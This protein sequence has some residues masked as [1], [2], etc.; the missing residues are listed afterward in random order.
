M[1][2]SPAGFTPGRTPNGGPPQVMRRPKQ[3]DPMVRPKD[4]TKRKPQRP[5][6]ANGIN[7]THTN[8]QN[9]PGQGKT[10]V[11]PQHSGR[12]PLA[13]SSRASPAVTSGPE[14]GRSGFTSPAVAPYTDYPLVTTKRALIEGMRHHV[15]K[16]AS[17]KKIDPRD[18]NE[19]TRPVR[20]HRRDTRAPPA[21]A[22]GAKDE[23]GVGGS[24]LEDDKERE[25]QDILR[26]EKDAQREAEAALVAPSTKSGG[27]KRN[28]F[29]KK[30]KQVFTNNQTDEQKARSK[31]RY[32]EALPWH[33]EDFEN[34]ST[35]VGSYEAALSDT[36]AMLVHGQ[37]GKFRMVPVEKWYKFTPKNHFKPMTIEEAETQMGKKVKEP[38]WYVESQK[39]KFD[40]Q[41]EQMNRRATKKL[42]VAKY[43]GGANGG[44][45]APSTKNEHADTDDLDFDEDRFADDEEA[46]VIEGD[47]HETK[48]AEDRIKRDQLQANIFDLKEEKEYDK[49]EVLEQKEREAEKK[50]GK[51]V[52]KALIKQEKNYVYDSDSS[53]NPYSEKVRCQI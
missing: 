49:A 51:K 33:L 15:A 26:A 47:D 48:Q 31:L 24:G 12:P 23:S 5:P 14:N 19:F 28:T 46:P 50:H 9:A 37:D 4:K 16:F 27:R 1:S 25:R 34:K 20:L 6:P 43:E 13:P 17:K 36:Y 21:G 39:D 8:G 3:A 38:R 41:E 2:A 18:E 29:Q 32:E 10:Q 52:K 35:W 22:G 53:D 7:F 45:A 11:M 44:A 42:F 40:K 30:T